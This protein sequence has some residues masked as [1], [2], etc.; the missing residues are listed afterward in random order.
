MFNK[1]K[2]FFSNKY[3]MI[4]EA[5]LIIAASVG[6]TVAGI[7]KS[8]IESFTNI[9]IAIVAGLDGI[10]TALAALFGKDKDKLE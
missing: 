3:V 2:E 1:I 6:L 8:Q 7:S 5:V 4:V 10:L 9:A